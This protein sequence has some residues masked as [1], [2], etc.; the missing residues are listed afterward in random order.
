MNFGVLVETRPFEYRVGLT[1]AAVDSLVRAGHQVFIEQNAGLRA[2]FPDE[3]Y[4]EVHA[5]VV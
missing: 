2:G 1:P 5:Q 3:R 4:H